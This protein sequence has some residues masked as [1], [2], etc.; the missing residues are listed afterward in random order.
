M[1]ELYGG[2]PTPEDVGR[3]VA[4]HLTNQ[5]IEA[6]DLEKGSKGTLVS[7]FYDAWY[8]GKHGRWPRGSP[9]DEGWAEPA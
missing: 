9:A 4:D 8:Y 3:R 7:A 6:C 2:Y 1:S 5:V